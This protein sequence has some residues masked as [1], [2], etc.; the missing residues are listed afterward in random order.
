M[1]VSIIIAAKNEE[2]NIEKC[3]KSVI[4]Q[5]FPAENVEIVVID[6]NSAD[7]TKE[8]ANKYTENIFNQ[9]PERS[10]QKNFGV[11]ES[12]GEYFLHLDADMT[13]GA[14]VLK[15]CARKVSADKDIIALY[16]P[17]IVLG[18]K[19]F[20]KVRR[21]ERGF[22][23]STVIDAVRFIRK[24]KFLEAG[25]FDEKLYAAEDWDLDK[26]LKKLGK[27]DIIKSPLC[28]NESEF[29]LKKYLS[30]KGYYSKNLNVYIEKWGKNDL[31]IKK[32]FGFYYRFIGVF[33]EN[34]KW[35]K[36]VRHPL[37]TAGMYFLRILVGIKFI[38]RCQTSNSPS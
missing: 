15:E 36:L 22:Y 38:F 12:R 2:K 34:G 13:L 1:L 19:Y 17:E 25:G 31:D 24:D 28:H 37:L 5:S 8:I 20:S 35:E 26:R 33:I 18:E 29:N 3:L 4:G 7:K 10:A 32:Q 23:N 27:F 21:F 9:G 11:R 14:N 30:K 16:I 6:N